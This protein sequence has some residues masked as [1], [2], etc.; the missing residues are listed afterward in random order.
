[1]NTQEITLNNIINKYE[2]NYHY[3]KGNQLSD[4]SHID[5]DF[6][7]GKCVQD[8]FTWPGSKIEE[9]IYNINDLT[10]DMMRNGRKISMNQ[11]NDGTIVTIYN[12]YSFRYDTEFI[13][14]INKESSLKYVKE[15][16]IKMY[17]ENTKVV[18]T[19]DT[20]RILSDKFE[21]DLKE[22]NE[23]MEDYIENERKNNNYRD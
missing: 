22:H 17:G 2:E 16:V 21:S 4:Y 9:G 20:F 10:W 19:N 6:K 1:M 7:N 13:T 12:P 11:Y 23:Q 3:R 15:Q 8:I 5:K 14:L 18:L